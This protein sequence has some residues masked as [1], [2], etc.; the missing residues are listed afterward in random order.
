MSFV[1]STEESVWSRVGWR[2]GRMKKKVLPVMSPVHLDLSPTRPPCASTSFLTCV[3]VC[4]V[5]DA[6]MIVGLGLI[7]GSVLVVM[8][9]TTTTTSEKRTAHPCKNK[10]CQR[11][12]KR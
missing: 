9:M 1:K 4:G 10:H 6:E 2:W 7:L 11:Q 3:R 8:M 5:H 12:Q